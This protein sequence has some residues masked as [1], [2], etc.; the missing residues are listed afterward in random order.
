MSMK[1]G[2]LV[3]K[4][5]F[6][7]GCCLIL[8]M[9]GGLWFGGPVASANE[10]TPE[11]D[12]TGTWIAMVSGRTDDVEI[13]FELKVQDGKL[14]GWERVPF[15][16]WK[17]VDGKQEGSH[18]EFTVRADISG[19]P[20]DHNISG[21]VNGDEMRISAPVPKRP[22]SPEESTS[23]TAKLE[24][25]KYPSWN[26][27]VTLHRGT[28]A[29]TYRAPIV[30]YDAL[31]KL[32]LPELKDLPANGLAQTP[33]MGWNSWNK[34]RTKVDDRI[35]R[36]IAD[37]MASNGMKDA[38][39]MYVL[40]DDGWQWKRDAAGV[41]QPNPGFPDM[42]ALADYVH[43]K[44]LKLGIYS[45]PGPK[46]CAGYVGS[47]DHEDLDAQTWANWGIDYLKYDWCSASHVWKDSDMQAVYQRMGVALRK[48]GRPITFSLCQYGRQSVW[49]WGPRV[50][51]NLWRTT[52]DISDRW[53]SMSKIGFSQS[54]LA[55][56]AAPGHWNDPD[57]LEVGNGGMSAVEYRTHFSMWALLAAPLIAGNDLRAMPPEICEILLNKE[58]IAIDQ[59][60]LGK[61]G[62]RISKDGQEEV[63]SKAL[64]GGDYAVALFNL[65]ETPGQVSVQWSQLGLTGDVRVRDLWKHADLGKSKEQFATEVPAHGVVLLRVSN[66]P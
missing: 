13:V 56:Y 15:G 58:V 44:G 10:T 12:V 42:K 43:S 4:F 5:G 19:Q 21:D 53:T 14:T 55:P 66:R 33:P 29:P 23:S 45:S 37:A 47:Y 41:L 64:R 50:G 35:V 38:G 48:V 49:E 46:T 22:P 28:P 16:D 31:P 20:Q 27:P 30:D 18:I 65:G 40:I 34:F 59:D 39:Y 1:D 32:E 8:G 7:L 51:G 25:R 62:S 2:L 3:G 6:L 57:M 36:G 63:W 52:D 26:D 9:V 17:I 61:Q 54:D 11:K 60:A 24:K